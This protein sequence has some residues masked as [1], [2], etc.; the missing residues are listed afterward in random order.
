MTIKIGR[1]SFEGPYTSVD[2]LED[3]SGVYSILC[4]QAQEY[5][6]IDIGESSEVKTRVENHDR[7]ECWKQSCSGTLA[8]SVLY[9][10]R[11]QRSG[12]MEIEQEL[13]NEYNP[14]CGER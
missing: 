13:R 10:P 2:R 1:Y 6:V 14:P 12:R 4:Q 3:R 7:E 8:V 9:T 5:H 11:K